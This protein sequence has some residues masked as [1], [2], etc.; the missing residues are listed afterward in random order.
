MK[1]A[2][3]LFII[4]S[5][6]GHVTLRASDTLTVDV[7]INL[8]KET[9]VDVSDGFRGT[10]TNASGYRVHFRAR[11]QPLSWRAPGER[12]LIGRSGGVRQ[13][14]RYRLCTVDAFDGIPVAVTPADGKSP[15]EQLA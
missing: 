14:R 11:T 9:D 8:P 3:G 4:E 15:P 5:S 10:Y 2:G 1:P 13:S 7:P 12:C 6:S